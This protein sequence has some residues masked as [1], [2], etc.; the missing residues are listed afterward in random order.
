MKTRDGQ[1]YDSTKDKNT[2]KIYFLNNN[3]K[4][5]LKILSQK[6]QTEL[7]SDITNIIH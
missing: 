5:K 3:V 6:L 1:R 4:E 2:N 7:I